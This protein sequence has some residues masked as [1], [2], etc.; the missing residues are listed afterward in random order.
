MLKGRYDRPGRGVIR[1]QGTSGGRRVTRTID[2]TL[3]AFEPRHDV[4]STLWA[5]ARVD[6]LMGEDYLGAQRGNMRVD[7]REA[8]TQLGLQF[9]IMTQFTSFVA[10]EEMTVTTGGEPRRIEVPV[11]MPEGV[12]YEGVFGREM[13]YRIGVVG[14]VVS[15]AIAVAPAMRSLQIAPKSPGLVLSDSA[16]T[17][18]KREALVIDP[19]LRNKTGTLNVRIWLSEVSPAVLEKLKKLGFELVLQPRTAKIVIGRIASAK[20]EELRKITEVIYVGPEDS[21][22]TAR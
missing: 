10:V 16:A 19:A 17:E 21:I 11:E 13:D 14:G 15:N 7:V 20:L 5:R 12:S 18:A 22:G 2:V 3:P 6:D 9:R 8:V 4:L 1:L